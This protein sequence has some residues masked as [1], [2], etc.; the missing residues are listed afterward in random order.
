MATE[1]L[2]SYHLKTRKSLLNKVK[3][4]A[5]TEDRSM[6]KQFT[7]IL[8]ERYEKGEL[9]HDKKGQNAYKKKGKK[10]SEEE[11]IPW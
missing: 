7:V 3:K 9:T 6:Q 8:K 1:A 2:A 11:N 5:K 10:Q 4:E